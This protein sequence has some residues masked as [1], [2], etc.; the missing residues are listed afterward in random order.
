MELWLLRLQLRE[1]VCVCVL[2]SAFQ[3]QR[4]PNLHI[5]QEVFHF[6]FPVDLDTKMYISFSA[7]FF[8]HLSPVIFFVDFLK[9]NR[10]RWRGSY[11]SKISTDLFTK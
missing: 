3:Y 10:R 1:F 9:K 7:D 2:L 11:Y 8:S 4:Y 5:A 6:L